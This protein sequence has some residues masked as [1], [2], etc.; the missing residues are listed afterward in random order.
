M[1]YQAAILDLPD[2]EGRL[3]KTYVPDMETLPEFVKTASMPGQ[4]SPSNLFALVLIDDGKVLK[5][6]ATADKGSTWLS[7]LYFATN[8]DSL[9]EEAQKV[10]AAHLT[11]ACEH[12]GLDVPAQISDISTESLK[13]NRVDVSS[14]EPLHKVAAQKEVVEYAIERADGSKHYPLDDAQ[15]VAVASDYFDRNAGHFVPRERREFAVKVAAANEAGIPLSPEIEKY[16]SDGYSPN[17]VS[18]LEARYIHLVDAEAPNVYK[19]ALVKLAAIKDT[20]NPDEFAETLERLD[21]EM[22][23]DAMWD[24]TLSDPYYST[25]AKVAKGESPKPTK[26]YTVG[27]ESC[28]CAELEELAERR[29]ESVRAH[30]GDSAASAFAKDPKAVFESMP[31]PQKK[32]LCRMAAGSTGE[33]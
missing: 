12:Y 21:R 14:Q 32:I 22:G 17:L 7:A 16:A 20:L 23:L 31:M 1:N 25:F 2:D 8:K 26:T 5:K 4:D 11:A 19:K 27:A 3:L 24:R 28:T 30:F 33:V 6:Y 29:I 15:S 10:A 18:H 13:D 9:P